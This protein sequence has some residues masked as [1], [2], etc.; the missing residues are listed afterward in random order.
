M[1]D[2]KTKTVYK[3]K[4][5]NFAVLVLVVIAVLGGV[6]GACWLYNSYKDYKSTKDVIE[7]I[8]DSVKVTNIVDDD[9][10]KT[11]PPDSSLSKFDIY[12]DYIKLGLIDVDVASLMKINSD[13]IGYIDVKGTDFNYP[14]VSDQN[15]FYRTHSFDKKENSNGWIYMD[16]RCS[17][18]E[19]GTNTIVYG[20]RLLFG[21]L[22]KD[23]D[24]VF[25]SSWNENDDNFVIRYYTN[26]YS[27]LWQIISVFK[28]DDN[29]G[30]RRVDFDDEGALDG[31]IDT[32]IRRSDVKFK[33]TAK[34]T[35]KFLTLTT[36]SKGENTVLFAKL[37]KIK[38]MS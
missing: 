6:W 10:T 33:A 22:F 11:I 21:N 31:Y 35:D 25:K 26:H 8:H 5:K 20:N 13:S 29:G 3:F 1:A 17:L 23:L 38:T 19:L 30:V 27:T 37:I 4:W 16:E 12:W 32:M 36:N 24:V 18:E 7:K 9:K 28:T 14:V 2:K 15:G 34:N